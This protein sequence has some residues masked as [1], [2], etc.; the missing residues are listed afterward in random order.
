[1]SI[2]NKKLTVQ[3]AENRRFLSRSATPPPW[4]CMSVIG[5]RRSRRD[6]TGAK[7]AAGARAPRWTPCAPCFRAAA[8]GADSARPRRADR[9]HRM[10]GID[11][12]KGG[13]D[14]DVIAP[15]FKHGRFGAT[16]STRNSTPPSVPHDRSRRRSARPART[17]I[18]AP[19]K[20]DGDNAD[21][22]KRAAV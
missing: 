20:R 21:E 22:M 18:A 5:H 7:N 19:S 1:M 3:I 8:R 15:S 9:H 6:Y 17:K 12:S 4:I 2:T 13:P 10:R 14:G 16:A 11:A